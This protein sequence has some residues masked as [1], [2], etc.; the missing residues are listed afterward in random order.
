MLSSWFSPSTRARPTSATASPSRPATESISS[1]PH[2]PI[3]PLCAKAQSCVN[4]CWPS[5]STPKTLATKRRNLPV[6]NS[7]RGLP[8]CLIWWRTYIRKRATSC[9]CRR[10]CWADRLR[11][12]RRP[13]QRPVIITRRQLAAA[14]VLSTR[15]AR[16]CRRPGERSRNSRMLPARWRDP[17]TRK[18]RWTGLRPIPHRPARCVWAAKAATIAGRPRRPWRPT[19]CHHNWPFNNRSAWA[20]R[21]PARRWTL[22]LLVSLEWPCRTATTR[23][24]TASSWRI[25]TRRPP[26]RGWPEPIQSTTNSRH[27]RRLR[28]LT[29]AWKACRRPKLLPPP[30]GWAESRALATEEAITKSRASTTSSRKTSNHSSSISDRTKSSNKRSTNSNSTN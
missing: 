25:S 16:R 9:T 7:G 22:R 1:D 2:C 11:A 26:D 17:A 12:N 15:C 24:W 5:S 14:P 10:R 20:R 30:R 4:S 28:T 29:R 19:S 8:C 23:H 27:V 13:N 21:Q 3:R 18:A 6:L